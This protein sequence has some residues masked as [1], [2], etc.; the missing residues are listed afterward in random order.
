MIKGPIYPG[1]ALRLNGRVCIW[2]GRDQVNYGSGPVTPDAFLLEAP[3]SERVH[4]PGLTDH[5]QGIAARATVDLNRYG[6]CECGAWTGH[7]CLTPAGTW[8]RR[9]H[10]GRPRR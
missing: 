3:G 6:G 2:L 1:D 10:R 7:P 5:M 4:F 9:P 8:I